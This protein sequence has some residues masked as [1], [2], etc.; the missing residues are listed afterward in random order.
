[1]SR[2][3]GI[4]HLVPDQSGRTALVTGATSGLGL[5]LASALAE[6]GATVLVGGRDERRGADAVAR[7]RRTH[8]SAAV[9]FA[10]IDLMDLGQV[11]EASDALLERGRLDLLVNNAGIMAPPLGFSPDGYESQWATN[12]IGPFALTARLLPMITRT[13]GSRIVTVSS[14]AHA[15]ARLDRSLLRLGV[16]GMRYSP[17][18][19]YGRTKLANLLVA[20]ELQRRLRAAGSSTLSVAAHPGGAA[21]SIA[22]DPFPSAPPAVQRAIVALWGALTVPART[23]MESILTAATAPLVRGGDVIGPGGPFQAF[24]RPARVRTTVASRDPELARI[25]VEY[26]EQ[27][28]ELPL[29]A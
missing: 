13:A 9:E 10:R 21:T 16:Q 29:I 19:F 25:T 8:P 18:A 14:L 15:S 5:E 12:V 2:R 6:A 27:L 3:G 1:V 24:G 7:I 23:A 28:T 26:L 17:G 22:A 11:A 20:R 4:R